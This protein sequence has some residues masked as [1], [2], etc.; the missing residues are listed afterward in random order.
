MLSE[1]VQRQIDRLLE[2]VARLVSTLEWERL[3]NRAKAG[4][5]FEPDNGDAAEFLAAAERALGTD[6]TMA[7]AG[8]QVL[9][10]AGEGGYV[11]AD[12]LTTA[13]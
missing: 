9:T 5:A 13:R 11:L 4:T 10:F 7:E 2:E 3:R 6:G 8:E 12:K 1:R